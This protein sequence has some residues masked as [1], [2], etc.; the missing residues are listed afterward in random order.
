MYF[1]YCP[2]LCREKVTSDEDGMTTLI[3]SKKNVTPVWSWLFL[4]A[5]LDL[6]TTYV[7]VDI[8]AVSGQMR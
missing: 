7:V 8:K 1:K 2:K 3:S 4:V 6:L 5:P